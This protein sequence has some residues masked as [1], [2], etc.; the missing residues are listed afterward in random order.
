MKKRLLIITSIIF[1]MVGIFTVCAKSPEP[2]RMSKDELKA[3]LGSPDL[4]LLDVRYGKDW[5]DSDSK[6][7]GA[8]REDPKLF[9]SWSN[10][11]PKDKTIVLY[12]A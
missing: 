4:I 12:C 7:K 8:V 6:I 2:S 1:F 9:E 5:T 11:Y 3:M 10:K